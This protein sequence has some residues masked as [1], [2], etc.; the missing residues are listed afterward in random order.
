MDKYPRWANKKATL[1][2]PRFLVVIVARENILYFI[3]CGCLGAL[4][5]VG[6]HAGSGCGICMP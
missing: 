4:D 5:H 6:V 1:R 2:S 3:R